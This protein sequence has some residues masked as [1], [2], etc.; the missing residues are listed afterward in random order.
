MRFLSAGR[1]AIPLNVPLS[2]P[3]VLPFGVEKHAD[4]GKPDVTCTLW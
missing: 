1:F 4:Q 2:V 3:D